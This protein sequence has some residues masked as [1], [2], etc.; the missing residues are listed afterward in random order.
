MGTL[1]ATATPYTNL[2]SATIDGVDMNVSYK[3]PEFSFGRIQVIADATYLKDYQRHASDTS[4]IEQRLGLEGATKWRG[5]V[6]LIWALQDVWQAGVSAYYIGSYADENANITDAAAAALGNPGY[7][8]RINGINYFRIK[9]SI[10]TNAF[11]S[12]KLKEAGVFG[13]TT[14]R[15]GVV[16]LTNEAPPLSSDP[17][18]YDP[19][20]YQSMAEGRAY[21]LRITK[22]F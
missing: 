5:D 6:N 12:Y 21:S 2:A 7:I 15:L 8:Y 11:V 19:G 16:N 1:L 20:V 10:Q 22:D 14:F 17:A 3:S 18:G 4:P 13:N 9:S